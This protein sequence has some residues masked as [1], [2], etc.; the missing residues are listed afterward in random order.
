MR[1]VIIAPGSRGD[2]QPLV[3]LGKGL[4][5]AGDKV[6]VV[7]HRNYETLIGSHG[8]E[9]RAI[10]LDIQQ[11]IQ[12]EKMRQVLESGSLLTSMAHVS[13]QL[14][15]SAVNLA[16][17]SL[18]ACRGMDM[19]IA[20]LGGLFVGLALAEKTDLHFVQAHNVPITP[21]AAFPGTLLPRIAKPLYRI[22]HHI[23]RQ[24]LWQAYRPADKPVRRRVGAAGDSASGALCLYLPA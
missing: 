23:T 8:L 17:R 20:G 19:I 24:I 21:T 13:Q 10:E 1:I 7:T 22:S 6:R 18:E 12:G 15:R 9:F 2:I 5:D 3:A 16:E 4:Q 14:R 11:V